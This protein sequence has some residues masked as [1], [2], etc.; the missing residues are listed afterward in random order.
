M[1]I[2][3]APDS[4]KGSV[5]AAEAADAMAAGLRQVWPDAACVRLPMA[6]GGEGT[7]DAVLTAL[8]GRRRTAEVRDPLGRPVEAAYGW[9]AGE[10]LAVIEM[11]AA[12]GLPLLAEAERDPH[13]TSTAGTGD[14]IAAALDRGARRIVL[15]LGGS[16]TVDGGTGCLAALGAR[17][18]DDDGAALPGCGGALGRIARI[19]LAGLDPRLGGTDIVLA[20]DVR[21]PLLGPS[22]AVRVFGPQKGL[23]DDRLEDF[24]A[25]MARFAERVAAATGSDPRDAAGAGAAGGIAFLLRAALG[26]EVRDG[27]ALVAE[28]AGLRDA[29][30]GAD[31]ALTGE[32]R[33]DAQSLSGKVPVGVARIAREEGVPAA[34]VA[35]SVD[36]D[37]AAFRAEGLAT[38]LPIVDRPMALEQAMADGAALIERAAARLAAAL[39]LGRGLAGRR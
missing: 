1:R 37:P 29:L 21:N 11:A 39:E 31:L 9:V 22:G 5:T 2:V 18:L 8:D 32:G 24:E 36:G 17:F 23:P 34:A 26:A 13:R 30:R 15:G 14:L 7:V 38:V 28:L 16:A 3:L 19:D 4:F 25:A 35:G 27:F 6:D 20:T 33:L 12:S 10:R